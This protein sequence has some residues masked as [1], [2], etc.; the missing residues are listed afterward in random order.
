MKRAVLCLAGL[1]LLTVVSVEAQSA[2][3]RPGGS[4]PEVYVEV[5]NSFIVT[6]PNLTKVAIGD[7]R[8]FSATVVSPTEVLVQATPVLGS[9]NGIVDFASGDLYVWSGSRR[10]VYR[11]V[12]IEA[13]DAEFLRTNGMARLAVEPD[14]LL[15]WMYLDE[16]ANTGAI[17]RTNAGLISLKALGLKYEVRIMRVASGM[18]S[19][20]LDSATVSQA[21]SRQTVLEGMT[22][23]EL[24]QSL[25]ALPVVFRTVVSD[26]SVIDYYAY[27]NHVVGVSNG[28]VVRVNALDQIPE[29]ILRDA[30]ANHIP[31]IG[32]TEAQLVEALGPPRS[33]PVARLENGVIQRDFVYPERTV[34]VALGRVTDVVSSNPVLP[35]EARPE[36]QRLGSIV[37]PMYGVIDG[38]SYRLNY[39]SGSELEAHVTQLLA[40]LRRAAAYSRGSTTEGLYT[41]YADTTV[42]GMVDNLARILDRPDQKVPIEI[43]RTQYNIGETTVAGFLVAR[44]A[45]S[46]GAER[47]EA[48]ADALRHAVRSLPAVPGMPANITVTGR[49]LAM[50]GVPQQVTFVDSML[51]RLI[52]DLVGQEIASAI[53]A[54]EVMIGMTRRQV[55]ASLGVRLDNARGRRHTN[56]TGQVSTDFF[57]S[58]RMLTFSEDLLIDQVRYPNEDRV[59]NAIADK[60]ILSLMS[61]SDV[62]RILGETARRST[63]LTDGSN[64]FEYGFGKA[65]YWNDRLLRMSDLYGSEIA[66]RGITVLASF[67]SEQEFQLLSADEQQAVIRRGTVMK[68]MSERDV[69]RTT[70]EAPYSIR[71]GTLANE[72]VHMYSN[73][74]VNFR[75]GLAVHIAP[76]TSGAPRILA[77][78]SRRAEDVASMIRSSFASSNQMS[79][80]ADTV[81]NRLIIRAT[82]DEYS[83]VERF[84]LALDQQEIPQVL[85][86]ARFV[87]MSRSAA[88]Q[89]GVQWGLSTQADGGN[90]P[91]AGFAGTNSR[92]DVANQPTTNITTGVNGEA[93]TTQTI[94]QAGDGGLILG[95]LGGNGLSFSGLRYTNVDVMI[96]AMESKGDVDVLS[97]PRIATVN[98]QQ[99]R[100]EAINRVYDITTT[101]TINPQTGQTTFS[102]VPTERPVGIT[103]DVTPTIGQDGIIT[104]DIEANSSNVTGPPLNFSAGG[105]VIIINQ[106]AERNSRT[107]VMVRSGTPLVMGGLATR[108]N[109]NDDRR[110]PGLGSLPII[111]RLFRAESRSRQDDDLLI[112]LTARVVPPEGTINAIDRV[113]SG[114]RTEIPNPTPSYAVPATSGAAAQ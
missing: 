10:Y 64:E 42:L 75:D 54:G 47:I 11:V 58:D 103:L 70:G 51:A 59:R 9:A 104:M 33:E 24:E 4:I 57:V 45:P 93:G 79:I 100:L 111:G 96:A 31:M 1:I 55:E 36:Y 84:A 15:V 62:E 41:I 86:E 6:V 18:T 66:R 43:V 98:G 65:V 112:F 46:L 91:F 99:A 102:V 109:S 25:G 77:L 16:S 67:N 5:G 76:T 21:I 61:R 19:G 60:K 90:R 56:G 87:Q 52:P 26:T 80:T 107:R 69:Q 108:T 73:F 28:Y 32:M 88:R 20:G 38:R 17:E 85:I 27:P 37:D 113:T 12:V 97:S 8:N 106:I 23:A 94:N 68:G 81:S 72:R 95:L 14:K 53:R 82:S 50:S 48:A 22:T 74:I 105:N 13:T 110:V 29:L 35:T 89:L 34:T 3:G 44:F 2:A 114:V 63:R 49:T 83:D 30:I 101:Q 40:S 71:A 78:K 92:T 39:L 7:P